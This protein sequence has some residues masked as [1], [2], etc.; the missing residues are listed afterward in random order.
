MN[1]LHT[2][3]DLRNRQHVFQNRTDAGRMLGE[4]LAPDFAGNS[5]LML[6]SIPMGGVPVGL[7]IAEK[8]SCA[9]DL[10]IVRK[11]QIPGNTEAGMGAMTQ[12]GDVFMNESL[13][14]KLEL[15]S[16]EV[17]QQAE[18]VRIGLKER[19]LRLRGGRSLPDL[20]GKAVILADDGL[21]SG[22]T[23]K[24]AIYMVKKRG[25]EKIV[26]AVPTAP[27]HTVQELISGVDALYCPNIRDS[28]WFAVAD[29]YVNWRDLSETEV[30]SMLGKQET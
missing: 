20:E 12:A 13:M 8:L 7:P 19:N 18:K 2:R 10:L 15:D 28:R 21:A 24:A 6:F 5:D 16:D 4:M 3:E 23:I 25:A 27:L 11:I 1:H 30:L 26:L 14:A 22:F 29:A 9:F 17:R